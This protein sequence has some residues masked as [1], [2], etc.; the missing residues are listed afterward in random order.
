MGPD[1]AKPIMDNDISDNKLPIFQIKPLK[2]LSAIAS[3]LNLLLLSKKI[4][5]LDTK[6]PKH[7]GKKKSAV[8]T[9]P[10]FTGT[11]WLP[12]I[13][14]AKIVAANPLMVFLLSA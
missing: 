1:L 2:K 6:I 14:P 11:N 5:K 7:T 4:I 12:Q 3:F 10:T 8:A 9:L 13:N